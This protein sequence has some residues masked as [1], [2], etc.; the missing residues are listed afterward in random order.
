MVK[1]ETA[2]VFLWDSVEGNVQDLKQYQKLS[3][4]DIEKAIE[5][6]KGCLEAY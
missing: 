5:I 3:K 1:G 4:E 6:L 2:I